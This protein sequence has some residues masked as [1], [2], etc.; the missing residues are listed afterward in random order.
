MS[1]S[2]PSDDEPDSDASSMGDF[3]K[4]SQEIRELIYIFAFEAG[5]TSLNRASKD[6][7]SSSIGSLVKHGVYR[8]RLARHLSDCGGLIYYYTIQHARLPASTLKDVRNVSIEVVVVVFD[9]HRDGG[10]GSLCED[11][12]MP[13]GTLREALA[14]ILSPLRNCVYCHISQEIPEKIGVMWI[15]LSGFRLL[16][17]FKTVS[18][19]EGAL[20]KTSLSR[21]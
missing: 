17:V 16:S 18:I 10:N 13:F 9:P 11:C 20:F 14:E 21:T 2:L 4:L 5:H 19:E 7:Y 12:P 8:V 1:Q 3:G 15:A 6:M